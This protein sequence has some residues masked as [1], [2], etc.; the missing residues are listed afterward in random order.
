MGT[1]SLR[2]YNIGFI[3]EVI[4]LNA[5]R[6]FFESCKGSIISVVICQLYQD[7]LDSRHVG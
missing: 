1:L 6:S 2:L 7:N 4:A 5:G 3:D